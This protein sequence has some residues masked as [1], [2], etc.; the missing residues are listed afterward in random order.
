MFESWGRL[1]YRRRRLV[2]AIAALLVAVAAG[3]GTGVFGALQSG[4]GFTVPGSP[5]SLRSRCTGGVIT[6][7]SSAITGSSPSPLST[8]RK[9]SAPGPRRHLPSRAV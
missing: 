3:W 6:P 9:S 2:L 1:V 8:A 7:R 4:G 5:S